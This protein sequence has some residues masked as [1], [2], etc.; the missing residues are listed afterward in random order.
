MSLPSRSILYDYCNGIYCKMQAVELILTQLFLAPPRPPFFISSISDP[1]VFRGTFLLT[2]PTPMCDG[3][4]VTPFLEKQVKLSFL[5]VI[6]YIHVGKSEAK[7]PEGTSS[8]PRICQR[9]CATSK[10]EIF[11]KFL[12]E[13]W[14]RAVYLFFYIYLPCLQKRCLWPRWHL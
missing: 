6:T 14:A 10:R 13:L 11:I 9:V 3:S 5:L 4:N 8:I 12:S 2:H 7:V 1:D